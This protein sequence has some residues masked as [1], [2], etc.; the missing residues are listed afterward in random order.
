MA[1]RNSN[2]QPP[3]YAG[4]GRGYVPP[5]NRRPVEPQQVS[6]TSQTSQATYAWQTPAY[7]TPYQ[8][9][10]PPPPR[11]NLA[12]QPQANIADKDLVMFALML[13][14]IPLVGIIG[15][16]YRPFLWVLIVLTSVCVATLWLLHIFARRARMIISVV[17]L[18]IS[19][20]A[21]IAAIDL[22]PKQEGFPTIGGALQGADL[23]AAGDLQSGVASGETFPSITDVETL[24][25]NNTPDWDALNHG[26]GSGTDDLGGAGG[27]SPTSVPVLGGDPGAEATNPPNQAVAGAKE[28]LEGYL[29]AWT[30]YDYDEMTRHT[31]PTWRQAQESVKQQL[32][33]MHNWWK[34]N[35]WT[36]TSEVTSPSADSVT[37]YVIIDMERVQAQRSAVK[38]QYTALVIKYDDLWYVD[39]DSMRSGIAITE[40]AAPQ[41]EAEAT[42]E[43]TSTPEPTVGPNTALWYNTSGGKRYHLEEHCPSIDSQYYS[44][45]KSFSYSELGKSP[46]SKLVACPTCNAPEGE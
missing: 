18:V 38:Q 9:E 27:L 6:Q 19:V 35:D 34:L 31:L 24:T 4:S 40:T 41:Q 7:E 20:V 11:R 32:F 1:N 46:Y 10:T 42:S 33:V 23:T 37:F 14:I 16:F 3:G 21:L 26:A 13:F 36:I 28:A 17:L 15:L 5:G 2:T 44:K 39:P 22:T 30:T 29:R 12:Q 8:Q 25:D 45:M 43:P